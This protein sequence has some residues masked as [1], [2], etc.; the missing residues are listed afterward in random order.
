MC[1][2]ARTQRVANRT[3]LLVIQHRR[4]RTH[5]VGTARIVRLGLSNVR[6]IETAPR[7]PAQELHPSAALLYPGPESRELLSIPEE[8][9]PEQ[10]VVLDG[11]WRHARS[12]FRENP[13]LQQLPRVRLTPQAPSRY[14]IRLQPA[15][16]CV[17]TLE[18]IVEALQ[19]L[20]PETEG[21]PGLLDVFDSMVQEQQAFMT[22]PAR[23]PRFQQRHRTQARV[24]P[25]SF[26]DAPERMLAVYAETAPDDATAGCGQRR[27]VRWSATRPSDGSV[28]DRIVRPSGRLP[29]PGHLAHMGLSTED[30]EAADSL[31]QVSAAWRAFRRDQ[32]VIVSWHPAMLRMVEWLDTQPPPSFALRTLWANFTHSRPGGLEALV[33]RLGLA[34]PCPEI[35]GRAS[36]RLGQILAI[37][38][39]LTEQI[40]PREVLP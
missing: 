30:V 10:L 31:E 23:T 13:W 7:V 3:Q 8:D 9:H 34:A 32:D 2:C 20:E 19:I 15:A 18:S 35:P 39:H 40:P 1:L 37:L 5:A 36:E 12:L 4:E 25:T 21:L 22:S 6:I 14:R 16:H 11:T 28:F 27:L 38:G 24:I 17:S 26:R 29:E 33:P